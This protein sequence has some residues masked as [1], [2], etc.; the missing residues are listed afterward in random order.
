MVDRIEN[1]TF[2]MKLPNNFH[3]AMSNYND[4]Y[5]IKVDDKLH[6]PRVFGT[7]SLISI[8]R[9]LKKKEDLYNLFDESNIDKE[10]E[11]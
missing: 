1:E 6:S 10:I 11:A 4:Y 3:T 7:T 9:K 5:N 2:K 8:D